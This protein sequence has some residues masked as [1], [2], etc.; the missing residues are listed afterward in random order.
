[1]GFSDFDFWSTCS[2]CCFCRALW[3]AR[4]KQKTCFVTFVGPCGLLHFVKNYDVQFCESPVGMKY[5]RLCT[6]LR[7]MSMPE[8]LVFKSPI[9]RT[10]QRVKLTMQLELW[11]DVVA[12]SVARSLCSVA[13]LDRSLDRL[14]GRSVARS[15]AGELF[16]GLYLKDICR[17]VFEWAD[18]CFD[19]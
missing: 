9:Q 8:R 12:R 5:M 13:L 2:V 14:L 7:I 15:I 4:F 1:M 16:L 17:L 3:A 11:C 18:P 19:F 10:S 6:Y